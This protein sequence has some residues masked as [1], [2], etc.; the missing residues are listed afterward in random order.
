MGWTFYEIDLKWS[1][2]RLGNGR[3]G[4]DMSERGS[5]SELDQGERGVCWWLLQRKKKR[6]Y[7]LS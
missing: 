5:I 2:K 1:G 6:R 4:N 3:S 7:F